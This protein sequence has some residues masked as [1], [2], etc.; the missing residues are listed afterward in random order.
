[1][2]AFTSSSAGP[3]T[4]AAFRSQMQARGDDGV[5]H[6]R[7]LHDAVKRA[8]RVCDRVVSQRLN[9]NCGRCRVIEALQEAQNLCL[10]EGTEGLL[11]VKSLT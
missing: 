6:I 4:G 2:V 5:G 10:F 3:A 9:G 8:M 1:M 11:L 7:H